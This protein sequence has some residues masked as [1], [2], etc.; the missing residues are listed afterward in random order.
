MEEQVKEM[1]RKSEK[2]WIKYK[3]I[4]LIKQKIELLGKK[5]R[6]FHKKKILTMNK[7]IVFQ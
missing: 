6:M 4:N 2:Y 3:P 5:K 1:I 7:M